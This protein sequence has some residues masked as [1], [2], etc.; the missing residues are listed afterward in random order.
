MKNRILGIIAALL[1]S[2]VTWL[3]VYA[4]GT[5]VWRWFE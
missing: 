2:A 3:F 5:V 1:F 4:L